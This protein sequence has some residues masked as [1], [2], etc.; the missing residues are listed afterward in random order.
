MAAI[1][2]HASAAA[3]AHT[4]ASVA[5]RARRAAMDA[6]QRPREIDR[7]ARPPRPAGDRGAAAVGQPAV[8]DADEDQRDAGGDDE[9]ADQQRPRRDAAQSGS[10]PR[11]SAA[12]AA[13]ASARGSGPA[14]WHRPTTCGTTPTPGY[15]RRRR[16]TM[17]SADDAAS[18]RAIPPTRRPPPPAAAQHPRQADQRQRE[19]RRDAEHAELRVEEQSGDAGRDVR[20]CGLRVAAVRRRRIERA[21]DPQEVAE[22]P[23]RAHDRHDRERREARPRR[24]PPDRAV[25]DDRQAERRGNHGGARVQPRQHGQRRAARQRA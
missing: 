7:R 19:H 13:A 25:A 6:G 24:A 14:R 15:S 12:P 17:A 8:V 11:R 2:S 10:R 3:P 1:T 4:T 5:R 23:R 20:P 22:P 9:R 21:V 18:R 16:A